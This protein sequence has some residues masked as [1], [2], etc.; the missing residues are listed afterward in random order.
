MTL[1]MVFAVL[2]ALAGCGSSKPASAPS[3]AA[4]AASSQNLLSRCV[5]AWNESAGQEEHM[6]I[7]GEAHPSQVAT[8]AIFSGSEKTY[9]L[10]RGQ[11][12]ANPA[13][14]ATIAPG[15][16]MV[17]ANFTIFVQQASGSWVVP[18][19]TPGDPKSFQTIAEN[20]E[21]WSEEH[22]NASVTPQRNISLETAN[23]QTPKPPGEEG[24]LTVMGSD[25]AF[26]ITAQEVGGY[27]Y[28]EKQKT[29]AEL[30]G[31]QTSTRELE[32]GKQSSTT[33]TTSTEPTKTTPTK[34]TQETE[35]CTPTDEKFGDA[36]LGKLCRS[37]A[38]RL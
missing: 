26:Q 30:A 24:K 18:S 20:G 31:N 7:A 11:E 4:T 10:L 1:V 32:K 9:D 28:E 36:R 22:A 5:H 23:G 14:W 6:K 3:S 27:D 15:A 2:G 17:V 25:R 8:V 35:V 13:A 29:E 37:T 33:P 19:D 38:N 34:P 12:G 16:C 21:T